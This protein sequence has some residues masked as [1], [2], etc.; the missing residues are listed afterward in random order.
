MALAAIWSPSAARRCGRQTADRPDQG[1]VRP[2]PIRGADTDWPLPSLPNLPVRAQDLP[3]RNLRTAERPM[4]AGIS[5]QA[6]RSNWLR[7]LSAMASIMSQRSASRCSPSLMI[8][9][10]QESSCG[11]TEMA[12][13]VGQSLMS[14]ISSLMADSSSSR[15]FDGFFKLILSPRG[16]GPPSLA[17]RASPCL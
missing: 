8:S 16:T 11:T 6:F 12:R 15:V 3:E 5:G 10:F 1:E 13:S 17:I 2:T 9:T 4:K 7:S 14:S